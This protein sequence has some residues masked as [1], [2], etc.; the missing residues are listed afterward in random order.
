M[1]QRT[2]ELAQ[3]QQ[4][5]ETLSGLLPICANCKQIRD[6]A[7]QWSPLE[8][9]IEAHS[10]AEFSHAICPQCRANLYG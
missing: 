7:G 6:A 1:H 8:H 4:Q 5:V 2:N 3:S 10:E 9:Y